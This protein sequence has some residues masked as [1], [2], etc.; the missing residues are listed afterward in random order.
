MTHTDFDSLLAWSNEHNVVFKLTAQNGILAVTARCANIFA[1]YPIG[2]P[3]GP[4]T[5]GQALWASLYSVKHGSEF[6]AQFGSNPPIGEGD[7]G[8]P[9]ADRPLPNDPRPVGHPPT[10]NLLPGFKP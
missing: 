4:G 3:V 5:V 10:S 6:H 7:C 1:E 2:E 8:R 9:V